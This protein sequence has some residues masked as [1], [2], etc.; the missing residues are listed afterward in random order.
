MKA[1]LRDRQEADNSA[2]KIVMELMEHDVT[3]EQLIAA[4]SGY[5]LFP[6]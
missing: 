6:K 2:L 3:E 4:A 1:E 5:H